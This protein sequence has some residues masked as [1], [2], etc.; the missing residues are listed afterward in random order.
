[1]GPYD[2]LFERELHITEKIKTSYIQSLN[3][4]LNKIKN[5]LQE[6]ESICYLNE[7]NYRLFYREHAL[8]LQKKVKVENELLKEQRK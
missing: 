1:M 2:D 5:D 4:S 3:Y 6:L 7:D 8:L